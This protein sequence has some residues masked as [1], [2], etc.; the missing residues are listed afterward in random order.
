MYIINSNN[1]NWIIKRVL[2]ET[3]IGSLDHHK[4]SKTEKKKITVVGLFC[5][6]L[7][8]I[9]LSLK[10]ILCVW[11]DWQDVFTL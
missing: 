10:V 8:Y 4:F 2:K 11:S 9:I 7:L 3:A 6:G 1:N 5:I